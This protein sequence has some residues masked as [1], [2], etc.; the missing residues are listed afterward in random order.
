[1]HETSEIQLIAYQLLP[2]ALMRITPA[3]SARA[4]MTETHE[5]FAKRCL[6]LLIANQAG[7]VVL[8]HQPFRATWDG[9]DAP[10]GLHI[11]PFGGQASYGV[12]SHFGH[13]IL[14]WNL[15]YLFRTS[16]GYNL[17]VRGPANAPKDGVTALEG[18]VETDWS[19]ATFTMNWK[20]TRPGLTVIFG[21]DEPICLLVPQ[22]RGELECVVPEIRTLG[23]DPDLAH[24]YRQWAASRA[25]FLADLNIPD[26]DAFKRAWQKDYFQGRVSDVGCP[27][28]EHQTKLQVRGF[29]H[30]EKVRV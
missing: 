11:E 14:T 9:N 16:P 30:K 5:R 21:R 2:G 27:F 19:P 20:L 22:R 13:G 10:S 29:E 28:P 23:M 3:S 4:W 1:M 25:Q 26:S 24:D 8:N 15:P 18:L 6:P 7:W 12:S 17:L